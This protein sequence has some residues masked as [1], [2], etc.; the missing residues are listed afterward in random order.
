MS[1]YDSG[2]IALFSGN[3]EPT[4]AIEQSNDEFVARVAA[5]IRSMP[6]HLTGGIKIRSAYRSEEEQAYLYDLYQRN[7]GNLA[8]P[9]G[10]SNHNHGLAMDLEF[11]NDA[12]RQWAHANAARYGL[13]FPIASEAW[14]VEPLGLREGTFNDGDQTYHQQHPDGDVDMYG[15]E[16]AQV[17]NYS[18]EVQLKRVADMLMGGTFRAKGPID[19]QPCE[20]G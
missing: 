7:Q 16:P 12:V 1:E 5:M 3:A 17:N 10:R 4:T 6:D 11:T 14:H 2:L 19:P 15:D 9:P 13:A 18:A 8:A 20:A